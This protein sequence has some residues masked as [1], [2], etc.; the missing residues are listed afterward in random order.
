MG[1]VYGI[2][3]S[4][5]HQCI[6]LVPGWLGRVPIRL[7]IPRHP[8]ELIALWGASEAISELFAIQ[9]I[10]AIDCCLRFAPGK[11]AGNASEGPG[12][13]DGAHEIPQHRLFRFD[14]RN[15]SRDRRRR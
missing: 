12:E 4:G 6:R 9:V 15:E 5:I 8:A 11:P 7:D 13:H 1:C 3:I 10:L 14:Q 2:G